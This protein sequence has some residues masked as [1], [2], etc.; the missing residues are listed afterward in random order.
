MNNRKIFFII[1]FC[2]V[3][4]F[5]AC[6]GKTTNQARI[7]S[8]E[9]FRNRTDTVPETAASVIAA[10]SKDAVRL[11][12]LGLV[13]VQHSDSSIVVKLMYATPDNFTKE[14]LY[15]DLREAYLQPDVAAMLVKAQ[16][17]LK[18][19]HPGLSIIIYDAARPLWCQRKMWN[20]VKG[21]PLNIYVSNP[22]KTGLH[23]YGAAVD[24]SLVD[25]EGSAL[26]MGTPFDFFGPE[27]HIDWEN[28]LIQQGKLTSA[29]IKNRK[30]LR[31]IMIYAGFTPLRTE[32]WHFNACTREEAKRKYKLIE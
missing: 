20:V 1:G 12:K 9:N 26:D 32:W 25:E 5:S 24:I 23:N 2:F 8:E 14:I 10:K 13:N 15:D 29:Q 3:F 22:A 30:I 28:L 6:N 7:L 17:K 21:T 4:L 16:K 31:D 11:E 18:E 27:A 19:Q